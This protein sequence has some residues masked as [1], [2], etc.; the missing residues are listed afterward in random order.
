MLAEF[1][2]PTFYEHLREA[3]AKDPNGKPIEL[4]ELEVELKDPKQK[5]VAQSSNHNEWADDPLI[6]MWAKIHPELGD[7]DL[8]PYH[9]VTS[10]RRILF[11]GNMAFTHLGPLLEALSAGGKLVLQG[12]VEEV[13]KLNIEEARQLFKALTDKLNQAE[14]YGPSPGGTSRIGYPSPESP[15]VVAQFFDIDPFQ[16]TGRL[17]DGRDYAKEIYKP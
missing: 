10:D 11:A 7:V 4:R 13:K 17:V 12:K 3:T 5:S 2:A 9:F 14:I 16:E 15:R 6:A 1:Y 8:R